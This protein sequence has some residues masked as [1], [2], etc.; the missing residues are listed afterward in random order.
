MENDNISQVNW[1]SENAKKM[2]V[3]PE[4]GAGCGYDIE[5][6]DANG[7]RKYVEVKA[8]KKS[9]EYGIRFYM[10]DFEFEFGRKHAEDYMV[11]YVCNV[12]SEHPQILIFDNVFKNKEFNKK[13]FGVEIS[14]EYIITAQ[15]DI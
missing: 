1:V 10:S 14:S 3:N 13:N 11:Y 7:Y 15:A 12:K 5:F 6:V 8:A 2:G 9:K 4:G